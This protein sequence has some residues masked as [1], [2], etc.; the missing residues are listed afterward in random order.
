[1]K[2]G[3]LGIVGA[4]VAVIVIAGVSVYINKKP[5]APEVVLQNAMQH[6]VNVKTSSSDITISAV[7]S[8]PTKQNIN[9]HMTGLSDS[10]DVANPKADIHAELTV[11]DTTSGPPV[12][13]NAMFKFDLRMMSSRLIFFNVLEV[14]KEVFNA[15]S[16]ANQWIKFDVDQILQK[17]GIDVPAPKLTP[18]QVQAFRV[19]FA[20]AEILKLDKALEDEYQGGE[21]LHHYSVAVDK[22]KLIAFMPTLQTFAES[23]SAKPQTDL[24]Q[25]Q[26]ADITT[27]LQSV[28][29]DQYPK[30][31]MWITANKDEVRKVSFKKDFAPTV[32]S[33]FGNVSP[34]TIHLS[35]DVVSHANVP[36][37]ITAPTPTISIEEAI[38]KVLSTNNFYGGAPSARPL[39]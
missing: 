16:I 4:I 22:D 3:T 6:L 30:F 12:L 14:P 9:L 32:N 10:T 24:E 27:Y 31:D 28:P 7:G 5:E 8:D 11:T 34:E 33:A 17:A 13:K 29:A 25:K 36:A 20:N 39:R 26:F 18:E 23:A 21:T 35:V 38:G 2:K 15:D 1:M 19:Q 37:S